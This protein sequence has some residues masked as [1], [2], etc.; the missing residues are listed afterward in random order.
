VSNMVSQSAV[1]LANPFNRGAPAYG[2]HFAVEGVVVGVHFP[3]DSTNISKTE[4]EYDVELSATLLRGYGRLSNVPSAVGIHGIDADQ[5]YILKPAALVIPSGVLDLNAHGPCQDTDGD[6]VIVQ[7]L[8]GQFNNPVITNL[9]SS[10]QRGRDDG[11]M[12]PR[13]AGQLEILTQ[14]PAGGEGYQFGSGAAGS[15]AVDLAPVIGDRQMHHLINGTHFSLDRN[16][17][18][19]VD[20]KPY[21]SKGLQPGSVTKKLVIQ[22]EGQDM[23]RLEKTSD[24]HIKLTLGENFHATIAIQIADGNASVAIAEPLQS[25]Y[26][27]L[28]TKLTA[29]DAH[30]HTISAAV[31]GTAT[32]GVVTGTATGVTGAPTPTV[33][34]AAW[35]SSINSSK[36]KIPSNA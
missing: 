27:A 36:L 8:N 1:D 16:G 34:A 6:R 26:Q 33:S 5:E 31:A 24:G 21:P 7:F 17:D 15:T 18:V 19:F 25:L 28:I 9:L 3:Q 12:N 11:G 4:M 22:N 32:G 30:T 35:D 14:G 13:Y 10:S 2:L 29:F 20:F 23:L